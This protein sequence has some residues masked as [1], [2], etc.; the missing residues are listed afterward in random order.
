MDAVFWP[1]GTCAAVHIY[2]H[3]RGN[4]SALKKVHLKIWYFCNRLK[5]VSPHHTIVF[6]VLYTRRYWCM[7]DRAS[8]MKMTRRINLMQQLWFIIIS[9]LYMFRTSICPSSGVFF[10]QVVYC[11]MWCSALGVVAVVLRSRCLVHCMWVTYLLHG[12]ESFLRS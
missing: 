7:C 11:C 2:R 9:S 12:A 3:S 4:S 5:D 1:G 10:I 6:P 8:Y